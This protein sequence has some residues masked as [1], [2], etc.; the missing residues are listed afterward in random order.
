MYIYLALIY[1]IGLELY[2]ILCKKRRIS[3][4]TIFINTISV[5]IIVLGLITTLR[6]S[7][8]VIISVIISTISLI[9]LVIEFKI[10]K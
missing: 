4:I 7:M 10:R 9:K 5:I 3:F 1:V 8:M 2:M 6:L